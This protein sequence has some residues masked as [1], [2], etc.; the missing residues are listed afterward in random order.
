MFYDL[1][2]LKY[3][4]INV[5]DITQEKINNCLQTNFNTLRKNILN[6]Q[7]V[8]KWEGENPSWVNDLG[9]TIYS[10]EEIREHLVTNLSE[11]NILL[12]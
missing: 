11:W 2:N 1:K 7:A 3:I 6:T 12:D 10:N 4:I 8:L 5:G 9:L